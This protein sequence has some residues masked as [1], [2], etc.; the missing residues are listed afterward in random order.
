MWSSSWLLL[1]LPLLASIAQSAHHIVKVGENEKLQF[2]PETL[3]AEVGDTVEYQFFSK[4]SIAFPLRCLA[5]GKQVKR[6]V[7][8]TTP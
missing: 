2:V 5:Q 3:K 8:L 4:V 7:V 1:P 6:E